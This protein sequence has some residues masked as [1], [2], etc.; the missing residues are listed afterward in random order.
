M[1]YV[2]GFKQRIGDAKRKARVTNLEDGKWSVKNDWREGSMCWMPRT[3]RLAWYC[4]NKYLHPSKWGEEVNVLLRW[5]DNSLW[6]SE[7]LWLFRKRKERSRD[8]R[9]WFPKEKRCASQ[10][11]VKYQLMVRLHVRVWVGY[12]VR[13]VSEVILVKRRSNPWMRK[14]TIN[15]PKS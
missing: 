3:R 2:K 12:I 9:V 11:K 8:L 1:I 5:L 6:E 4:E 15:R 10:E 13:W 14:A 7:R